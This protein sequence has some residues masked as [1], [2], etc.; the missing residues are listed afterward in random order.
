MIV[1]TPL[2]YLAATA[3]RHRPSH[4]LTLL[5]PGHDQTGQYEPPFEQHLQLYFHDITE[6]RAGLIAP[7]RESVGAILDFAQ[8][9]TGT[10]PLVVHCW[11]GISRSSAA[12]F[13]IACARNP[14]QESNIASE[15]RRRAPFATP[16]RLMV[17]LADD[18]LQRAGRMIAAIDRI[19]RGADAFQGVPYQLPIS[20]PAST[21]RTSTP[22]S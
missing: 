4:V 13:M 21:I 2:E 11:A 17:A 19:G 10:R 14:G 1:V 5:S 9:W 20:F 7:D 16:N 22:P 15:L 8:D 6:A 18:V 3:D 12:A